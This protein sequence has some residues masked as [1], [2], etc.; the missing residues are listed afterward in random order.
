MQPEPPRH[1]FVVFS[2]IEDND[3][4]RPKFAQCNNCGLVHKVTELAKSE[5][6]AGREAMGSIV[7]IEDIKPSLPPALINVLESN[8]ADLPTWEAAQFIIE[9]KR[10]GDFVVV[11]T[12]EEGGMRQGKYVR[13]L[14]E[15]LLKVESF[16]RE[17]YIK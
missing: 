11:S 1:Q 10:W 13:I 14:G 8:Q 2:I 6:L 5:V 9:N 12:D 4:V 3:K 17:E 16:T 15:N 7:A